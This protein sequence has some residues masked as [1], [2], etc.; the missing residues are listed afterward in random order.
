MTPIEYSKLPL[1]QIEYPYSEGKPRAEN[2]KHSKW[3]IQLYNNL[4]GLYLEQEVFHCGRLTLVS[5]V[6]Q[7]NYF[8]CT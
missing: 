6:G 3:I 7:A 5:S 2:T 4:R 8:Y 1:E